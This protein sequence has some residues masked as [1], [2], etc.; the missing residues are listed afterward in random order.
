M[1]V[2][3]KYKIIIMP[4]TLHKGTD[5]NVIHLNYRIQTIYG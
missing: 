4:Y 1:I 5:E 2:I 3:Y